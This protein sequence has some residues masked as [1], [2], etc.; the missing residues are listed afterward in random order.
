MLLVSWGVILLIYLPI[1]A[2]YG[3]KFLQ[4]I[5]IGIINR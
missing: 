2:N 4:A 3:M 1:F 5:E